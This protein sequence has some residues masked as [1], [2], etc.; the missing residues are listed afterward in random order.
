MLVVRFRSI[1]HVFGEVGHTHNAVDQRLSVASTLFSHQKCIQCPAESPFGLGTGS[2]WEFPHIDDCWNK[3][4]KALYSPLG[5]NAQYFHQQLSNAKDFLK[6]LDS[7]IR[8]SRG[9]VLKNCMLTGSLDFKGYFD[10]YNLQV[11]GLVPNARA[12][13]GDET[14]VNHSW[15]FIRRCD[16]CFWFN[17]YNFCILGISLRYQNCTS[18]IFTLK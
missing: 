1:S 3:V 6:I 11:S 10:S 18:S 16:P 2:F 8:P 14:R 13:T 15:R 7:Q 9:R 12:K 17:H 5:F 4:F